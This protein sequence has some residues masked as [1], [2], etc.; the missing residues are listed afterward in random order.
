[1]CAIFRSDSDSFG[2]KVNSNTIIRPLLPILIPILLPPRTPYC[3]M[4]KLQHPP[5]PTLSVHSL[6]ASLSSPYLISRIRPTPGRGHSPSYLRH[7]VSSSRSRDIRYSLTIP[8]LYLDNF[9][10]LVSFF[11]PSFHMCL[12]RAPLIVSDASTTKLHVSCA[13]PSSP[14]VRLP[15]HPLSLTPTH[16]TSPSPLILMLARSLTLDRRSDLPHDVVRTRTRTLSHLRSGAQLGAV[17]YIVERRGA[18]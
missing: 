16:R 11:S 9:F 1:M 15:R 14:G 17:A 6:V 3:V 5:N 8:L 2:S 18:P 10:L 13:C 12:L 4:K 7:A